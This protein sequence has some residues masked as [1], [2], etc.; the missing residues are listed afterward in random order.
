MLSESQQEA[1]QPDPSMPSSKKDNP[2]AA[3][4]YTVLAVGK[5][6]LPTDTLQKSRDFRSRNLHW[7]CFP[8]SPSVEPEASF[9]SAYF[10]QT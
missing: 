6:S 3:P 8:F 10:S 1:G 5:T 4:G 2:P 7:F 9:S